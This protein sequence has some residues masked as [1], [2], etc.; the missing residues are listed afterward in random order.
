MAMK[1][2]L[3]KDRVR[4]YMK[5]HYGQKAFTSSGDIKLEYLNKAID[6]EKNVSMKKALV[7]AKTMR[8]WKK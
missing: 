5:R 8:R 3:K 7:L 6:N 2:K 1:L 4:N